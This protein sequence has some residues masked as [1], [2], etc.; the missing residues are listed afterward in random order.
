MLGRK[1]QQLGYIV[2]NQGVPVTHEQLDDFEDNI[3]KILVE[4]EKMRHF[5]VSHYQREDMI[6]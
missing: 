6:L 2:Q 5:V 1:Y 4:M 3:N